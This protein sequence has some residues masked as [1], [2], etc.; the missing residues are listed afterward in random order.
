[1]DTKEVRFDRSL[2]VQGSLSTFYTENGP[3]L[4]SPSDPS[5]R[6]VTLLRS[7]PSTGSFLKGQTSTRWGIGGGSEAGGGAGG[8]ST[9]GAHPGQ[10]IMRKRERSKQKGVDMARMLTVGKASLELDD[11]DDEEEV[12]DEENGNDGDDHHEEEQQEE[13]DDDD[14]DDDVTLEAAVQL[15]G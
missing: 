13:D 5:S 1:M 6:A 12:D 3:R 11:D 15:E 2:V 9:L 7:G 4:R 8:E 10:P 14:D